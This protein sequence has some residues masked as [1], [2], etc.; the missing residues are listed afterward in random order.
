MKKKYS[1]DNI[2]LGI[3]NLDLGLGKIDLGLTSNQPF[4]VNLGF[5]PDYR[6]KGGL[7]GNIRGI[8]DDVQTDYEAFRQVKDDMTPPARKM[9]KGL[10]KNGKR[11]LPKKFTI[12]T[13]REGVIRPHNFKTFQ[14]AMNFKT[15]AD[16]EGVYEIVT[17]PKQNP[18][19][20]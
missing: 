1:I 4:N 17:Y 18:N 2:D 9:V 6:S 10:V 15:K 7:G 13:Q 14:D 3:S 5:G 12:Y 8:V 19:L 11:L 16:A 20:G